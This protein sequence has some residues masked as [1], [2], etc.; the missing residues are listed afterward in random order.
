MNQFSQEFRFEDA[1][2]I[3]DRMRAIEKSEIKST[4][5][6]ANSENFDIF[7][8]KED[9]NQAVVVTMFIRDGK[10]T[11]S[12][13][14]YF[15]TNQ[16]EFDIDEAYTRAIVNYYNSDIPF[17][18]KEILI[19]HNIEDV[20]YLEGFLENK[21]SKK[22]KLTTPKIGDKKHLIDISI[23][24][25]SEL[26]RIKKA[27][28][29][30][31][32]QTE[33]KE[34]FELNTIPSRV[35]AFDNSHMM[36]QATVGAMIVWSE[37]RFTKSS[38]RHYN[39]ESKDEYGQMREMLTNR[40]NSFDRNPPP[41][42]WV[43]DGGKTLRDLAVNILNSVGVNIDVISIAKEKIDSKA[44]RAKGKANDIIHT[45][46]GELKLLNSDKRLHF[47]QK[48]R[49]EAHRFV[50]TYHKKQKLKEDKEISLL[51][52]KGIGE[53]KVQKLLKYYGTFEN[54]KN[55]DI[56]SLK[57]VI[58]EKDATLLFEYFTKSE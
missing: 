48:L 43:I 28:T 39:L 23:S 22:I 33:I 35:E 56:N 29:N 57:E 54:I 41:E 6:L 8:I 16:N 1:M 18:P 11:S 25:C 2:I 55:A 12:D 24:N 38:Y 47:V 42:L 58:N 30:V 4:L 32:M 26:L 51:A 13:S 36:G 15:N 10:L 37:N 5:D 34:L 3:R 52:I 40:V 44:H 20:E 9:N 53:A 49:D 19:A 31:D 45:K 17:V 14:S 27:T 46:N 21:F 50:I 7:A